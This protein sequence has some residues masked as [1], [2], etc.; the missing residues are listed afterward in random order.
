MDAYSF[1]FHFS[2]KLMSK[3]RLSSV[4]AA[5]IRHAMHPRQYRWS[6]RFFAVNIIHKV[7]KPAVP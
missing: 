4:E 1:L 7:R 5:K 6:D 3:E 2:L